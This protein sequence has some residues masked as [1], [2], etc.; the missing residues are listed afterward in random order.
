MTVEQARVSRFDAF[1]ALLS[2]MGRAT[3]SYVGLLIAAPILAGSAYWFLAGPPARLKLLD[4]NKLKFAEQLAAVVGPAAG[5]VALM[6]A[7]AI[8]YATW[9]RRR[10][11]SFAGLAGRAGNLALPLVAVPFVVALMQEGLEKESP[12]LTLFLCAIVATI[13]AVATYRLT[14][15]TPTVEPEDAAKNVGRERVYSGLAA[16][17]LVAIWAGYGW[18]FTRLSITNHHA[19]MT[20]T[21]DLGLYDQVFW[22][23]LHGKF[24]GCNFLKAGYHGSAHFDPI[25]ALLSP[26]YLLYPRA[27][28]LLGLQSV[29]VGSAVFPVYFIAKRQLGSRFL[30]VLA[31]A[32]FALH[33]AVHGANMYEF[34]SLTMAAMPML[35][36]LHFLNTQRFRLYWVALV[37]SVLVREDIP[38]MMSMVGLVVIMLG[39]GKLRRTGFFTVVFCA[40][41]FVFVKAFFMTSAGIIMSGPEAYSYAYYYS[42]MIPDGK[43]I[44]G[45]LLTLLTNPS[46]VL[47]H[48]L[49]EVKIVYLLKMFLPIGFFSFAARNWRLSLAYGIAFTTLATRDA[50]FSTAFQYSNTIIPFAFCTFP[51]GIK[52]ASEGTLARAYSLESSRLRKGLVAFAF[53]ASLTVSFKFGGFVDNQAFRGG[54]SRVVRTLTEDQK[55]HYKWMEEA[56]ALIP[57]KASVGV[58]NKIGPHISNRRDVY[59]YGQRNVQYVFIDEQEL[60]ADRLKK[61]KQSIADGHLQE[62]SRRKTYA[63]F[64]FVNPKD[65]KKAEPAPKPDELPDEDVNDV[66]GD[67]PR[68]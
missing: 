39:E 3:L 16:L 66:L 49:E 56:K 40:F 43:G 30:S 4:S 65:V 48:A 29:W 37:A 64:K 9:G 13:A 6:T 18:F 44:G 1:L 7:V 19:L 26:L 60:K 47:R 42:E 59:F 46:F 34:H 63:V 17:S 28:F 57:P 11:L 35:W 24:L 5:L 38:L 23:T 61:H 41:Y 52:Q 33:P 45:M 54:F 58:T 31:A 62:L 36:A 14:R 55:A 2:R 53:L 67:D 8:A 15:P 32:C 12:K 68:E 50:V 25:L 51:M 27:E 10:E 21:I 20:R 22:Q